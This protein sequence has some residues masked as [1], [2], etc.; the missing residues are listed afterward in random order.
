MP[1]L[2][3]PHARCPGHQARQARA[4][5]G[6][7]TPM[8]RILLSSSLSGLY[9]SV[10]YKGRVGALNM[11]WTRAPTRAASRLPCRPP[12]AM[13]CSLPMVFTCWLQTDG[14]FTT[15]F[16]TKPPEDHLA[17]L[18]WLVLVLVLVLAFVF[19]RRAH[20]QQIHPLEA[21]GAIPQPS[22]RYPRYG[23]ISVGWEHGVEAPPAF[24]WD[25]ISRVI[26]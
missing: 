21:S 17:H 13:S 25:L 10:H 1:D 6:K 8:N 7:D 16:A 9:T 26:L 4:A 14:S 11:K 5:H 2:P 23:V 24:V 15:L 22:P 20:T 3:I 12:R 18:H 19:H